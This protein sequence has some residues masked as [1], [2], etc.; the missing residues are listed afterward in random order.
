MANQGHH[1]KYSESRV[2]HLVD[3]EQFEEDDKKGIDVPFFDLQDILAATDN[4]SDANKLGEGGFGPV[5]KVFI[6]LN[7]Q[8]VSDH[9]WL[10]H[11]QLVYR[12]S[13]QEDKKWQ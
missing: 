10:M 9:F 7:F 2:K 5:Y 12:A 11:M 4:F 8:L 1:L 3:S 13:F 6:V